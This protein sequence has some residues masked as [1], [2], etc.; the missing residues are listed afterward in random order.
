MS[1]D[2]NVQLT[3]RQYLLGQMAGEALEQF[4]ERFFVDDSLFQEMLVAEDELID[5]SLADEL[6]ATESELFAKNFLN[7]AE[8]KQKLLFRRVLKG[9]VERKKPQPVV[10]RRWAFLPDG[11]YS[12]RTAIVSA[13]LMI[14][15]A[16]VVLVPFF[17][18][19]PPTFAML[20]LSL[21]SSQRATGAQIPKIKLPLNVDQLRLQLELPEPATPGQTYRVE[22]VGDGK[23]NTLDTI[24]QGDKSVVV[25]ISDS[26]LEA[27]QYALNLYATKP[28]EAEQRID[29]SYLFTAE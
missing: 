18:H 25:A 27:G 14:I 26:Q 10:R 13:A 20:N 15:A 12:F 11:V 1:P 24:S 8:R 2:R 19:R 3:I 7:S 29:G 22:L 4:E 6:N 23:T 21:V 28:G 9:Y 5:E 17:Q 16:V